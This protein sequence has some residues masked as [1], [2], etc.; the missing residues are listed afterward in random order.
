[1]HAKVPASL[2]F[3]GAFDMTFSI[4]AAN[5][6]CT[7]SHVSIHDAQL[8]ISQALWQQARLMLV[9]RLQ[10]TACLL[11]CQGTT[12]QCCGMHDAM[13]PTLACQHRQSFPYAVA[14][15]A[16]RHTDRQQLHALHAM[17]HMA[18]LSGVLPATHLAGVQGAERQRKKKLKSA[19]VVGVTCCSAGLPVLEGQSFDVCL[20]DEASQMV[21][22]LTLNPLTAAKPR[23]TPLPALL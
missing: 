19:A 22:P 21:E 5:Q 4:C 14:R 2:L 17:L 13:V 1:M 7:K 10:V 16:V 9:Y 6:G 12:R 11:P 18:A 8:N 23:C 20:L 15:Y 3:L